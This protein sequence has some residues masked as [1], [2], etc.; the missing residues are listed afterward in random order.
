MSKSAWAGGL[1][2]A[3]VLDGFAAWAYRTGGS[4]AVRDTAAAGVFDGPA[5]LPEGL[6]TA[7]DELD[8]AAQA[9]ERKA[10]G[11]PSSLAHWDTT[12]AKGRF[13]CPAEFVP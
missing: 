9:V 8:P 10:V 13:Q 11:A 6:L 12:N 2:V 3:V 5:P 1:A 7:A 4:T